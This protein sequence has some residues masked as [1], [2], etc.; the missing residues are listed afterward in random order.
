MKSNAA[1]YIPAAKTAFTDKMQ[2]VGDMVHYAQEG[3][4]NYLKGM[5][6]DPADDGINKDQDKAEAN[7][8][9]HTEAKK[10]A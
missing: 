6:S 2:S 8:D 4:T 3:A 10:D 5:Q 7:S 9:S 1:S